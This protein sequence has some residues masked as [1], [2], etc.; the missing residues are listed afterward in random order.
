MRRT[1]E[2]AEQTRLSILASAM[3]IFYEKGYSI[4]VR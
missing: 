1:K 4:I 3:D 2:D